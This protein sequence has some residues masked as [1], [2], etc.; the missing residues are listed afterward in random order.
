M[1]ERQPELSCHLA[2]FHMLFGQSETILTWPGNKARYY[3]LSTQPTLFGEVAMMRGWG[4]I[5]KRGG[6]KTE[7]FATEREAATHFLELARQKRV[8]GYR[9]VGTCGNRAIGQ[10]SAKAQRAS[11]LEASG[12]DLFS[13]KIRR[14]CHLETPGKQA[15]V[16]HQ[17]AS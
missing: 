12:A 13:P 2:G 6:E 5:G 1:D 3:L 15:S 11:G 8:K 10:L 9:P 7:M 14:A 16:R 4:R 17:R